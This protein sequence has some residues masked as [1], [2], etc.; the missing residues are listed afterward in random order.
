MRGENVSAMELEAVADQHPDV[1]ASAAVPVPS[2]L[3]EDEILLYVEL[4]PGR[5]TGAQ[6]LFEH[7]TARVPRFM[8]PRYLRFVDRLPRTA[9]EKVQKSALP[10]TL[11]SECVA[12]DELHAPDRN[13]TPRAL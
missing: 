3:G 7:I 13:E 10:R 12:R 1:G 11:D 4:K 5:T 9:T 8:V 6:S 2:E